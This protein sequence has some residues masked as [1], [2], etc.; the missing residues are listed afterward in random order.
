MADL[1]GL[2]QGDAA[3]IASGVHGFFEVRKGSGEKAGANDHA[4]NAL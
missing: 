3:Q 4:A 1:Y 2:G